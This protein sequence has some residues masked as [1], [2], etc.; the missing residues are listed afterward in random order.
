[1]V[2][3]MPYTRFLVTATTTIVLALVNAGTPAA[4]S[5]DYGFDRESLATNRCATMH[6]ANPDALPGSE[7][8]AA[9]MRTLQQRGLTES[10]STLRARGTAGGWLTRG[11]SPGSL[12]C[13]TLGPGVVF[14]GTPFNRLSNRN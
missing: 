5:R 8:P 13:D 3:G 4:D 10:D 1:M 9:L 2:P 6:A 12:R 14:R 7:D 11:A